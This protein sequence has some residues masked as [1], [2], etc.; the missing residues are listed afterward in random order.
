MS[1]PNEIKIQL[2]TNI[3]GFQT[4][5]YKPKMTIPDTNSRAV[6]FWP[7]IKLNKQ[8]ILSKIPENLRVKQF[9]NQGLFDSMLN[10]HGFFTDKSLQQASVEGI[11]DNN[12]L[13]T[14]Q[15]LFPEK[16]S[17]YL[18]KK[19]YI[20]GDTKWENGNWKISVKPKLV[21]DTDRVSNPYI[22]NQ[23]IS[24]EILS[25]E[26]QLNKLPESVIYGN[27][28]SGVKNPE[29]LGRGDIP[30][31]EPEPIPPTTPIPAP[32][33]PTTPIPAPIPPTTPIP[34]P[35]PPT[36]PITPITPNQV[37]PYVPIQPPAPIQPP[38]LIQNICPELPSPNDP[39]ILDPFN[40]PST[41]IIP[42]SPAVE[43]L[44]DNIPS[45]EVDLKIS[46]RSTQNIKTIIQSASFKRIFQDLYPYLPNDMK[47]QITK[48]F[49]ENT[50]IDVKPTSTVKQVSVAAYNQ[51]SEGIRVYR[52][53]GGGDCF[54]IA[55]C[56]AINSNNNVF[57]DNKIIKD[58]LGIGNRIFTV[59]D[60]RK[61]IYE[62]IVD[63]T[64]IDNI[65]INITPSN[66]DIL[67]EKFKLQIEAIESTTRHQLDT[68]DYID[69]VNSNYVSED[70]FLVGKV[71]QVPLDISDY[72]TPYH[73]IN[74][75]NIKT[76]IESSQ[77]WADST[78]IDA[79]INKLNL[80]IIP[81]QPIT[82][83]GIDTLRI[84]DGR[85]LVNEPGFT[86]WKKYMFVYNTPGHFELVGFNFKKK[87]KRKRKTV[88]N[89][90]VTI[91]DRPRP[92]ITVSFM[93]PIYLILI[94]YGSYYYYKSEEVRNNFSFY[95]D[96]MSL[97]YLAQG[98]LKNNSV[99]QEQQ[100]QQEQQQEQQEVFET[101]FNKYFPPP[102]RY[103]IGRG[104]FLQHGGNLALKSQ[105]DKKSDICYR[106]TINLELIEYKEGKEISPAEFKSLKCK[107][108]LNSIYQ[109]YADMTGQRYIPPPDYNHVK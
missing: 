63:N 84:P 65:L 28:F 38:N 62:Y 53:T 90:R 94:I 103:Q 49:R 55:V 25:G 79:L 14:L 59:T 9:F 85:H 44:V 30:I 4:I 35:I 80:N 2:N 26:Q 10:T 82:I 77:Y 23:L 74:K 93:A 107:S 97:L 106:I 54:F 108:Q 24:E 109:S 88:L 33:P 98:Q 18:N 27:H 72:Y 19:E 5:D 104:R 39:I 48:I 73:I 13:V 86:N 42:P 51:L 75:S 1:I 61:M 91:F 47:T 70:N 96:I 32:I 3:P 76:Y 31:A 46:T 89:Y 16:G 20:I 71:E 41:T 81:I 87:P 34:A 69:L 29:A 22:Y 60:L 7:L 12:I 64:D 105:E 6:Y 58:D 68:R 43:E 15:F 56:D 40:P 92:N 45:P 11:V 95:P 50:T 100:E 99:N 78:A 36:T 17:L 37:V 67:N 52:N 83:N 57:P 66:V 8:K 21:L 101:N 102:D